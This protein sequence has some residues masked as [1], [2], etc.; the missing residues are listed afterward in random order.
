[1]MY[2]ATTGED[3]LIR[4]TGILPFNSGW[5]P[6]YSLYNTIVSGETVIAMG[7][8][9]LSAG[10]YMLIN[11]YYYLVYSVTSSYAVVRKW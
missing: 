7:S 10:E 8:S 11:G 4:A 3:N 9:L 1:M 5:G 2:S 6:A